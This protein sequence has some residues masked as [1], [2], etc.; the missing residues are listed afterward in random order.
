MQKIK[1]QL[2]DKFIQKEVSGKEIDFLLHIS[3]YQSETGEVM[4]V[5]YKDIC[6]QIGISHQ[7]FYNILEGL[8]K[9]GIITVTK[10]SEIDYDIRIL[11]NDFSD[12]DFSSGYYNTS[13][14]VFHSRSF[15]N[16]KTKE[17]ILFLDLYKILKSNK[18]HWMIESSNFYKRYTRLLNVTKKVLRGYLHSLK[19]FFQVCRKRFKYY[20]AA[21]KK[22][23]TTGQGRRI[24]DELTYNMNVIRSTCRRQKIKSYTEEELKDTSKLITQYKDI[25]AF[26]GKQSI[27]LVVQS[28]IDSIDI[29][30]RYKRINEK[31][32]FSLRPKLIHKVIKSR[33]KL[34]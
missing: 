24:S 34:A 28:L 25:A 5:Y 12:K 7:T 9:K 16:L 13:E 11:D 3:R 26:S 4:G 30:N 10:N 20:F 29:I 17:K 33:L 32:E 2:L 31:R 23:R 21:R 14:D 27:Q 19:Q 15:R 6:G 22:L 1:Y 8:Q 18:G